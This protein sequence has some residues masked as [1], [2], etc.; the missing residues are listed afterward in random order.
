MTKQ[1]VV[2]SITVLED[3]QIQCRQTTRVLDDDRTKLGERFLRYVLVPGQDVTTQPVVVRRIAQA[4]W[5]QAVI[6]AYL[7]SRPV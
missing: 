1:I 2:D 3:G 5:T 7:A 4:V 6:D